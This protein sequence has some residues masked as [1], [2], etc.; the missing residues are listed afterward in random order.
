[1]LQ[2]L[3]GPSP[4]V[5]PEVCVMLQAKPA[6]QTGTQPKVPRSNGDA[7]FLFTFALHNACEPVDVE[8][9]HDFSHGMDKAQF[10]LTPSSVFPSF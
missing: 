8:Y 3:A 5:C 7:A 2:C 1:M 10:M 6:A 9:Y 4:E